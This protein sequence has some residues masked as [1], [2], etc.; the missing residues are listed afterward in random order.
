MLV[1]YVAVTDKMYNSLLSPRVNTTDL[2]S[3]VSYAL[4]VE[5]QLHSIVSGSAFT[6]LLKFVQLL[7]SVSQSFRHEL[8]D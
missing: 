6:A 3:A 8:Q 1:C 2:L 5:V 4:R 7:E